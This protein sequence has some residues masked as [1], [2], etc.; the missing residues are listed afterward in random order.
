M[1]RVRLTHNAVASFH[2]ALCPTNSV[3]WA[4]GELRRECEAGQHSDQ[5]PGWLRRPHPSNE[6]Y[7][8]LGGGNAALALRR[9]RAVMCLV[10]PQVRLGAR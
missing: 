9:G 6:G 8:L 4:Y 5:P 7:L 3:T 2:R 1:L 10:N